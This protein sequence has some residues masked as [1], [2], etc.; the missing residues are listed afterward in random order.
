MI[1][2]GKAKVPLDGL[3]LVILTGMESLSRT[4]EL[5]QVLGFINDLA[6][7]AQM[8]PEALRRLKLAD[9]MTIM[10]M[11]RGLDKSRFVRPEEEVRAEIQ[12]EI[13]QQQQ[14]MMQQQAA[15]TAG[16]IAENQSK[17]Q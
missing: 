3:E 5:E 9:V 6:G 14:L 13:Q 12:A 10:A 16:K 7:L 1:Q 4:T 17:P 15:Q 8:P 11:G 2:A